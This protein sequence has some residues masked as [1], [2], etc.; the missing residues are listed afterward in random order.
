MKSAFERKPHTPKKLAF[1]LVQE[2]NLG[3]G[4]DTV[5]IG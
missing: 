5:A 2:D 1:S 4:F 3:S